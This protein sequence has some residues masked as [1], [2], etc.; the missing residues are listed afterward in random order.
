[1]MNSKQTR[2]KWHKLRMADRKVKCPEC[3]ERGL[4]RIYGGPYLGWFSI[5]SK[6]YDPI[7]GR[8]TQP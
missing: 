6:N 4:H 2:K 3:G 5:C 7:T 8:R 1:M